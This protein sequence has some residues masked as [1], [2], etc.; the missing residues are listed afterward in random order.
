MQCMHA[1]MYACMHLCM[2]AHGCW[3]LPTSPVR[4][5]THLHTHLPTHLPTTH[6]PLLVANSV[7]HIEAFCSFNQSYYSGSSKPT[8]KLVLV[9][10][11]VQVLGVSIYWGTY[12]ILLAR[13]ANFWQLLPWKLLWSKNM[14]NMFHD[15]FHSNHHEVPCPPVCH[16]SEISSSSQMLVARLSLPLLRSWVPPGFGA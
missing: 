7:I 8:S 10:E 6:G 14:K 11:M 12:P 13:F 2:D 4:F 16:D 1:C 9:G 5:P 15:M 3:N